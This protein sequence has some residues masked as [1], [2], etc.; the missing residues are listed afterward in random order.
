[1]SAELTVQDA[2]THLRGAA[3]PQLVVP[4]DRAAAEAE[5]RDAEEVELL[6]AVAVARPAE[7]GAD[8][9]VAVDVAD[10]P[11]E[12]ADRPYRRRTPP[13]KKNASSGFSPAAKIASSD[14]SP[15]SAP[16]PL[17]RSVRRP[18]LSEGGTRTENVLD[19]GS[20]RG[21]W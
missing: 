3:D 19:N 4:E 20:S 18:G 1:M 15:G 2:H 5:V 21:R 11:R 7:G 6:V 14:A 16:L 17:T 13:K 8:T 9:V 10:R 12:P